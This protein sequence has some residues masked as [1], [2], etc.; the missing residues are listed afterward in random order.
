MFKPSR[1]SFIAGLF[2]TALLPKIAQAR[3]SEILHLTEPL[4]R[5]LDSAAFYCPYIPLQFASAANPELNVID[6]TTRYDLK[7]S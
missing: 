5:F 6:F 7:G 1:R 3:P 2:G 4:P